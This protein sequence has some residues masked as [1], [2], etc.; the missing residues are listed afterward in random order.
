MEDSLN[1]QG[2]SKADKPS[3]IQTLLSRLQV[4]RNNP[5]ADQLVHFTSFSCPS[6]VAMDSNSLEVSSIFHM[7]VVPSKL[8]VAIHLPH[9]DQLT[10]RT[11]RRWDPSRRLL[12]IQLS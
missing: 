8:A 12:Q 7:Q 11:V 5:L 3:Q 2:S 1:A 10:E 6:S 4:A 9:G